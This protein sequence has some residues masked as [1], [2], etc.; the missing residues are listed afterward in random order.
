MLTSFSLTQLIL[1]SAAYLTTLFGVAWITERGYVPRRLVRHPLVYTLSLGVYASAWAFY[2]T[3][4][5]AY[6]Y[7]YGFLAI[8]LGVSGA[9]L[10]APVLLY[11][12]LRITRAYQLSSLADLFAFRFRSTWAGALTTLFM[13]I[14]VLPMLALQIEAVTNSISLLTRGADAN[15]AAL[16]F[17]ALITLF[18]I[19]F[20]AR[21][22]A[23]R[24]RHEGLVMA[25]AF[26]SLVKLI[27]LGSIGLFAL[28]G[29][30]GGPDG[31]EVWL[32]Q[33]QEALS[34]LHTPLAE[35]P[36]RTLLLVFFA[37][38]IV[39]PHMYHMTF[40]ENLNPRALLSASWGLPLFL[41][42]MSLAVPPI[43]WAGLHLGASTNPEYFTLGLGMAVDSPAL[44]LAAF[45]GGISA[46]SGLIIVMTLALSGM[47]LNHLVLPLYQPPAEG[48]IYRWLKWTRRALIATI[49][50]LGYG[51]YLLLGSEQ[52]LSNLGIVSFVATLQFLPGALSVLYWPAANRRGF[53]AGLVA[54]MLVWGATMLVPLMGN[55]QTLHIPLFD[56]LYVLDEASWH[57]AALASLAANVLVFTLVSLFSEPSDE[58]KGAAEAC[59]VDNV[60]RPQ[61]RELLAVSPQEFASQLAKPLGA[62]TAQKEVEQALRDLHLPFDERRPYALRRL[63][64]RIEANLS[65][66]MG[67]SVA[68]DMV[69]T[70]LP[71]KAS[72]ESYVTEDIHFIESRL[73]DYHSRLTGLAAEL[74]ALRRYHR[75]TLQD[76]PMGVCSLAKDQE[77]LMWNRAIE[78]L[79]GVPAQRVVGSRL[80]ALPDPW[81][82]LLEGFIEAPDQHLHKQR[83]AI[84]GQTRWLNLHK[85]AIEEPLAPGNSGLVLLVEDLT[86]TQSLEDKL[87]HSERLASIGRLAAG[88]AH[89][90]GNPITGIACLAQNLREEREGD[91]ELTEI[92]AQIL[93]QT[94]R[95]S[96]I[97]QSL[98]SFAHAGGKQVAA[99]PV[100]LA[101]VTQEA[102]SLLS[103]N[104]RSVEVQFFNLCDPDHWVE[105]DAQRL[106]QVLINLL[107][108]ARDASPPGGA[109]RV[110]SEASENTV[111]LIVEDEGSGIPKSIIDRLFEPFFTTK[112]PGKGTGLGLALVYSIV[113][114]HYG[115]ITIDSP[116]DPERECGTRI[117]VTLPRHPGPTAE[118]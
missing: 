108:N 34:T 23:T 69:E 46:A 54:G 79:T 36:W 86:E 13:L 97:V 14:G 12:I 114:E 53:I 88:V 27:A 51:F 110:R 67:P 6:Q 33:N 22:I 111:D 85:A 87:I 118:Q 19:L 60:R 32:L 96:R 113:E 44:A 45:I 11:P 68:Q 64:D 2:G 65:G 71:Y 40:T 18:A 63:R 94:K 25:I 70:F 39:M 112:D 1:I 82:G 35:G 95:V 48:N 100:C 84:D 15:S 105:G 66:L 55:V 104:R 102:I 72:S 38:A 109:I 115:Q 58:E 10:L 75:Q 7:G 31:L 52:E 42:P 101:D 59:A 17:C 81:K 5:L 92:S 50:L 24:E 56:S 90:I 21:H 74:D 73:E 91:G 8:Y 117:R 57:L 99:E 43:L 29:V 80:S 4:G 89:E 3:V 77:V 78:E 98:M 41:L 37:S 28:Y 20:G 76:L 103:L 83:L 49:I 30:F 116:A 26:E 106:A 47:V 107:S 93:E 16:A 61:R 62:K 9:F